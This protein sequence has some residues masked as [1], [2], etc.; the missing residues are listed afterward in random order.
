MADFLIRNDTIRYKPDTLRA[1]IKRQEKHTIYGFNRVP[2]F[3]RYVTCEGK[4]GKIVFHD[5]IYGE[6]RQLREAYF[7]DKPIY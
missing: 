7:A 1:W 3:I 5:D 6:D 4:K 2:I